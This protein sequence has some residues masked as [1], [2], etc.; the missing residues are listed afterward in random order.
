MMESN[1]SKKLTIE[2]EKKIY[3]DFQQYCESTDI[4]EEE[5]VGSLVQCFLKD[6]IKTMDTMRKGYTEMAQINL[7]ICLEY[8]DCETGAS[9]H[10]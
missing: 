5:L 4:D 6:S 10:I 9:S 3:K 1:E 2:V 7:D 8:G